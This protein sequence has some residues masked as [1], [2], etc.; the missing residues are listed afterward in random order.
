[1]KP[2]RIGRV[3]RCFAAVAVALALGTCPAVA[4]Q[5]GAA[6]DEAKAAAA[7]I[8]KLPPARRLVLYTDLPSTPEVD[9]LPALFDQAFPQWCEYFHVPPAEHADWQMTG[10]LMKDKGRFRAAGLLPEHLPPFLHGYSMGPLLW[11]YDQ[12]SDYYR[13]HLLLHEGTHGF[14]FSMLGSC[15]PPWYMEGTAELMGTHRWQDDRLTLNTMPAT[16]SEV[17]QLGRIRIV[18]DA[19]AQRRAMRLPAIMDYPPDAYLEVKPYAWSWAAA[20]LLDHHPRYRDRFRRLY[21]NVLR[22]DFNELFH[23]EFA[24]DWRELNEEW[25]VFVAGMEYGYDF[26]RTAIDFAPGRPCLA[27]GAAV[28]IAADRGWQ[29]SGVYLEE[30]QDYRVTATGRYQV[31]K[32]PQIWWCEPGGV[33]MRYYKGRPLGILLAAIRPEKAAE[34]G[35]N[36]FL[37]PIVVGLGATLRPDQA[38]TLYLKINHSAAELH[39]NAGELTVAVRPAK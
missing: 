13:R 3:G 31:G 17:P 35:P 15:G 7:G 2:S 11:L 39:D 28:Q 8:R 30:G 16:S 22:A 26:T 12:P 14:M 5:P 6:I 36:P 38:G 33:S 37:R 27:A 24:P 21:K 19:V 1:M 9:G 23:R 32:N 4:D 25:G 10:C 20:V 29:P 34:P 18:K